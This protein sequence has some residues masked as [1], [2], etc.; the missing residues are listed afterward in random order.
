MMDPKIYVGGDS[1]FLNVFKYKV[2]NGNQF[3]I[4]SRNLT[5]LLKDQGKLY[6]Y[7]SVY[8]L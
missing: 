6:V 4:P 1:G 2:A 8:V 3:I 5:E 7:M